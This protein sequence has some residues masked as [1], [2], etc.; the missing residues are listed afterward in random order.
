MKP[1]PTFSIIMP[2]Y[3]RRETVCDAVRALHGQSYD[4]QI[5]II[6]VVDGS[7]DGTAAALASIDGPFPMRIIEQENLGQAAARNRGAAEA[8]GEILLFLDDDMICEPDMVEQHARMYREGADAVAGNIPLHSDSPPGVLTDAV[9]SSATWEQRLHLSPLEIYA[10]Q[11]SVRRSAFRALGGFDE[12]FCAG[13]SYG[14]DDVEFGA[15]LLRR[16]DVRHN[17]QAISRQLNL[18]T[19]REFMDRASHLAAADIRLAAKHPELG[20]RLFLHRAERRSRSQRLTYRIL[21]ASPAV[22]ALLASAMVRVCGVALQTRFRSSPLLARAF[23]GASSIAYW[24][25]V[26]KLAGPAV[27]RESLRL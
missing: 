21:S 24:S 3:Q 8:S 2:T 25:N 9:A 17:P 19:A 20:R 23:I 26:R 16:F 5:E 1:I 6:V 12:E 7:T 10:G 22:A 18:V 27:V 4:G 15:R 11:L 13:G 14:N